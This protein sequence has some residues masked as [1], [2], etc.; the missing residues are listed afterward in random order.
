[1]AISIKKI[2]SRNLISPI[3]HRLFLFNEL[4]NNKWFH[5]MNYVLDSMKTRGKERSI[6]IKYASCFYY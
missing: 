1:M 5:R 3:D 4:N 2:V 6:F